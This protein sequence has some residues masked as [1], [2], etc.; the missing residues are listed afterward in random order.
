M[1]YRD[2]E[3]GNDQFLTRKFSGAGSKWDL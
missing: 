2:V 3:A 1:T